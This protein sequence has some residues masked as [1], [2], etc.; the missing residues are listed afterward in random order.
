MYSICMYALL[1]SFPLSE[2]SFSY[3]FVW[4]HMLETMIVILVRRTD[5][6]VAFFPPNYCVV[7]IIYHMYVHICMYYTIHIYISYIHTYSYMYNNQLLGYVGTYYLHMLVGLA[8]SLYSILY[9]C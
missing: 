3:L 6:L 8:L 9:I 4:L 1:C 2:I 5:A 7:A